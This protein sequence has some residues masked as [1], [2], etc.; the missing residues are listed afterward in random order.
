MKRF[1]LLVLAVIAL[2]G[3]AM[4]GA[5]FLMKDIRGADIDAKY[6]ATAGACTSQWYSCRNQRYVTLWDV[7]VD[8]STAGT[9]DSLDMVWVAQGNWQNTGSAFWPDSTGASTGVPTATA[10][11][12]GHMYNL[13]LPEVDTCRVQ[14]A[15]FNCAGLEFIRF[16]GKST[17]ATNPH[18]CQHTTYLEFQ[19]EYR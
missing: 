8:T 13:A 19:S 10:E 15:P 14:Y 3:Q 12:V 5:P 9:T 11:R 18:A 16:I 4:A 2:A 7:A 1:V 6:V 17:T